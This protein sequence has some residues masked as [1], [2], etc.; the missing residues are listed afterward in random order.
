MTKLVEF[1]GRGF[2]GHPLVHALGWT[3]L[4]FLWQGALIALVLW[5]VLCFVGGRSSN[6]RYGAACVTLLLMVAMPL[7]T[8][9]RIVSA[10]LK[11]RS[12]VREAVAAIDPGMLLQVSVDGP[13]APWPM[14]IAVALDRWVPWLLVAW[15]AGAVFFA[16]RLNFGLLVARRLKSAGT[17]PPPDELL[18]VFDE[19]RVLVGI[20]RAVSLLHSARVQVP[21]VIGWLRPVVLIPASC[22]TG[23]STEQIE[24]IFCHE[25]AHVRRH[26]YL[27]S[28]FQSVA[29]ALLFY[30]PAVWWVSKQVRRER[31]CCCD[32]IAV[33][34]GGDVLAYAKALSYLEERRA[35]FPEFVLGANGGVLTMRIKRLLG[36]KEDAQASRFAA[37]TL[38]ALLVTAAG[39]YVVTAARAQDGSSMVKAAVSPAVGGG[40]QNA[41][42]GSATSQP[43]Q[44]VQNTAP[45]DPVTESATQTV[46]GDGEITGIVVDPTGAL[47]PRASVRVTNIDGPLSMTKVTNGSGEY[48]FSPLPPGRY[49]IDVTVPG[50]QRVRRE[51]VSIEGAQRIVLNLQ[52]KVGAVSQTTTVAAV[53][54]VAVAATPPMVEVP[55]LEPGRPAR[56]SAGTMA[57]NIIFKADPVYPAEAR[58]EHVE[59]EVVLHATIS[60]A[61]TIENV[62]VLSGPPI[63][64]VS[65]IDAVRQWKYKPYLLN[66]EPTEVE[67]TINIRYSLSEP[68]ESGAANVGPGVR[69]IGNGVSSPVVIYQVQPEYS[70]EAR[71]ANFNGIE[72]VNLIVDAN[73][74][75]QNVHILR[76]VGM[77]LD[78]KAVE[79]VRQYRFKPAMEDGKPVPVELNVEINFRTKPGDTPAAQNPAG[80]PWNGLR[81]FANKASMPVLIASADPVFFP[82]PRLVT[83]ARPAAKAQTIQS[84]QASPAAQ[85]APAPQP[86]AA[87]STSPEA[88]ERRDSTLGLTEEQ[89]AQMEKEMDSARRE[90]E[91]AEKRMA[92]E[93]LNSPEFRK[94][95]EDAQ[96]H[97]AE[98]ARRLSEERINSAEFRAQMGDARRHAEDMA[99]R[100]TTEHLNSPEVRKEMEDAQKE[101]TR[102]AKE[103]NSVE[104]RKQFANL[105]QYT[106]DLD[107]QDLNNS[108]FHRQME[109]VRREIEA[110]ED[111]I[112]E[113][114]DLT[115]NPPAKK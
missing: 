21:T 88:K 91:A 4:H 82:F 36:C 68:G 83:L 10:E 13:A 105:K 29:E 73:G 77:G 78:E 63:L 65:A 43:E 90:V 97:V 99:K 70:P 31:E 22:L 67:T 37:F 112:R 30:H 76:G 58:A 9:A 44:R 24:A 64:M 81:V 111:K 18:Q 75:P 5:L 11:T 109:Q 86:A 45:N 98:A 57:G 54:T 32:E 85:P 93:R 50:F 47:V 94:Q 103:L 20:R 107:R 26:D 25:L 27:V 56:V 23:L 12:V 14:R 115:T 60:K 15:F 16:V 53:P 69:K 61:G 106:M 40:A 100:M 108:T 34:M 2:S 39:S 110:A 19:L 33:E 101:A 38:I 84:A 49:D 42:G 7:V 71:A 55:R 8:F 72:L 48:S 62:Q 41:A 17:E 3:L 80:T 87:Q 66:G 89:R 35:A 6:A 1:A 104:L 74:V 46:R 102:A 59:G 92:A 113:A 28:V 114:I 52:V 51:M 95:M 79:A 96:R